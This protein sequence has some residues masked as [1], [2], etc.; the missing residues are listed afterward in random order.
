MYS[1]QNQRTSRRFIPEDS[2]F[3]LHLFLEER[4]YWFLT[5]KSNHAFSFSAYLDPFRP[6]HPH[7]SHFHHL[8]RPLG[9]CAPLRFPSVRPL[10]RLHFWTNSEL[11]CVRS[12]NLTTKTTL[13]FNLKESHML[14]V[15]YEFDI[16]K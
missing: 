3:I 5:A 12:K 1:V 14:C 2:T 9:P 11:G 6:P 8:R 13:H 15:V 7:R 4:F 10:S 16:Y